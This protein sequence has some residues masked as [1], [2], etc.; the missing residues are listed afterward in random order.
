MVLDP[1]CGCATTC[2][3]AERLDRKW[4]GIDLSALAVKLV[5]QRAHSELGLMGGIQ[6]IARTDIPMRTD[7]ELAPPLSESKVVLYGTQG[8]EL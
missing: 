7:R 6:S 5:E 8:W 1:F 3:A 2:I 4:I